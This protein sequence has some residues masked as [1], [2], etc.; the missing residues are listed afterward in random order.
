MAGQ[1]IS[2]SPYVTCSRHGSDSDNGKRSACENAQK[3]RGDFSANGKKVKRSL[4]LDRYQN[5]LRLD[6]RSGSVKR[7]LVLSRGRR[8]ID[9]SFS[10]K[11]R[12]ANFGEKI[13]KT[14]I[15]L[16]NSP[17]SSGWYRSSDM[18]ATIVRAT[19]RPAPSPKSFGPVRT[20]GRPPSTLSHQATVLV[21]EV[22][23][24]WWRTTSTKQIR[25][26]KQDVRGHRFIARQYIALGT[27][28]IA[29][30]PSNNASA[31]TRAISV[32]C[33]KTI[34]IFNGSTLWAETFATASNW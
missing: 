11:S 34:E 9:V 18:L 2:T 23:S 28:A 4:P 10:S 31:R 1:K 24:G 17:S 19:G 26:E 14:I 6:N 29:T 33:Q 25:F 22:R 32:A 15:F 7:S 13:R 5:W 30:I 12:A 3:L 8:F 27:N 21:L 20:A 16:L